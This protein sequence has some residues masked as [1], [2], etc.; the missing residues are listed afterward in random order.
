M[1][2]KLGKRLG[3]AFR[4]KIGGA[5][6]YDDTYRADACRDLAAAVRKRADPNRNV[7]VLLNRVDDPV[8]QHEPQTD[9]R[10]RIQEFYREWEEMRMTETP[11]RRHR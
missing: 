11:R 1:V 5:P 2:A 7:D 8:G 4:C 9:F 3:F 6:A 10:I